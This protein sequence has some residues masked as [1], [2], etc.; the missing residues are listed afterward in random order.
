AH[1]ARV[2]GVEPGLE[3]LTVLGRIS[4]ADRDP[5]EAELSGTR[6][7]DGTERQTEEAHALRALTMSWA[8]VSVRPPSSRNLTYLNQR[9]STFQRSCRPTAA[10][11]PSST[12][13]KFL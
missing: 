13:A 1:G 8:R 7:H 4:G 5:I 10:A 2:A 9:P 6:L 3:R 12:D 11:R